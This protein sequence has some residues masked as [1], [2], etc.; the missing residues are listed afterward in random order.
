MVA[1]MFILIASIFKR[2]RG[3]VRLVVSEIFLCLHKGRYAASIDYRI[4]IYFNWIVE[5]SF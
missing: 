4:E 2:R 1:V 5:N 3:R